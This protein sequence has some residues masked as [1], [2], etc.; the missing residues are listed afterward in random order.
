MHLVYIDD[1]KDGSRLAFSGIC[2]PSEQWHAAL[3]HLIGMRR[4]MKVSDGVYTS[5]EHHATDWIGGRGNIA[6]W[7]V[8]KGARA[9]LFE[10]ALSCFV[11]LPGVQLFN[12]FGSLKNEFTLIERLLNRIQANMTE[13]GSRA[14]L[15]CDEGKSYDHVLRKHRRI[16]HIPSKLGDWGAGAPTKDIPVKLILEDLVYR[17]SARS[18]FIQ[19]ADF[20]AYALMRREIPTPATTRLGIVNS[21]R[22]LEQICVKKAFAK[23]PAKLGIIRDT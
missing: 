11:C 3:D 20:C 1:S 12:A 17:D 2:V 10:Y 21:F 4:Q 23:D 7:L 9:R 13:A 22:T 18:Y 16:N 6:P 8:P 15:L 14:I 5:V 19:A